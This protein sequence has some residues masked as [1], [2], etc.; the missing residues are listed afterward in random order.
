MKKKPNQTK[1][2]VY[3]IEA[4]RR[5]K[6]R[7]KR[8]HRLF[9]LLAA[10]LLIGGTGGVLYLYNRYEDLLMHPP[11]QQGAASSQPG[12][13]QAGSFPVA[14]DAVTPLEIEG[15]GS[16]LIL[17]TNEDAAV[18]QA[19]GTVSSQFVHTYTNPV[20]RTGDSRYLLYDRGGYGYRVQNEG[21]TLSEGRTT[22][23]ILNGACGHDSAFALVTSESRYAGSVQVYGKNGRELF[24]WYSAE[25]IADL[26]FSHD[27]R[28]LAVATAVFDPVGSL[29][30]RVHL[31]DLEREEEVASADFSDALPLGVNILKDG[32]VHLVADTF[33]GILSEDFS[34]QSKVPYLQTLRNYQFSH[35]ATLLVTSGANEVSSTLS[36]VAE[37]GEQKE[38]T[39]RNSV[40]DVSL[41]DSGLCVLAGGSARVYSP[42]FEMV[43]TEQVANDV[44]QILYHEG[45]IYVM[46]S[47]VLDRL[48][49]GASG[50]GSE[51]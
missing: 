49:S 38:Q 19:D 47:S 24:S 45:E 22:N 31:F 30:A 43:R 2:T 37:N 9:T 20:L 34:E 10:M 5:K 27:D 18:L 32:T 36:L 8:L 26:A 15:F 44:F 46:S 12:T 7:Q 25:Q 11:G 50:E 33:L 13:V 17:L 51:T 48:S 41:T 35:T 6:K 4:Y 42:E 23:S 40:T 39:V 14:L 29:N 16:G 1:E 3:D 28:Y 21:G